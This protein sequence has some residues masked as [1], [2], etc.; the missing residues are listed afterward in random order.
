MADMG[1]FPRLRLTLTG[2]SDGDVYVGADTTVVITADF[3]IT[4]TMTIPC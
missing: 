4:R 3:T 2:T 1:A